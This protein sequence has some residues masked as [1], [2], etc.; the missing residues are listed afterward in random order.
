MT[1]HNCKNINVA[2]QFLEKFE[3]ILSPASDTFPV[4]KESLN[5]STTSK[6]YSNLADTQELNKCTAN[7]TLGS[8][9]FNKKEYIPEYDK[10][11]KG[12][13]GNDSSNFSISEKA[14]SRHNS[15]NKHLKN[16]K[17][18]TLRDGLKNNALLDISDTNNYEELVSTEPNKFH[19][20]TS[21]NKKIINK[22]ND[23]GNNIKT[24]KEH[25]L[26][27]THKSLVNCYEQNKSYNTYKQLENEKL[28]LEKEIIES[29]IYL[30]TQIKDLETE[31]EQ[32]NERAKNIKENYETEIKVLEDRMKQQNELFY[33]RITEKENDL[34]K[35]LKLELQYNIMQEKSALATT[36]IEK[37]EEIC[38]LQKEIKIIQTQIDEEKKNAEETRMKLTG[39][40]NSKLQKQEREQTVYE[41]NTLTKL[42]Q[43]RDEEIRKAQSRIDLDLEYA[44]YK[45]RKKAGTIDKSFKSKL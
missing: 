18:G 22:V 29:K 43:E 11:N 3:S 14:S 26:S 21:H 30:K 35:R 32:V 19:V 41:V 16:S 13:S 25:L 5:F 20:E 17:L 10:E 37:D 28:R 27:D 40:Y 42:E 7:F 9:K 23:Y 24:A 34:E 44:K 2:S 39:Q 1:Y 33:T 4:L 12:K 36:I 6:K 8:N 31:I 45:L 38:S 15:T